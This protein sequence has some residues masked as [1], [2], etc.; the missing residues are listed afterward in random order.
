[1]HARK[2][3]VSKKQVGPRR[4][5]RRRLQQVVHHLQHSM[6]VMLR[7]PQGPSARRPVSRQQPN[8]YREGVETEGLKRFLLTNQI[9]SEGFK[10]EL[11]L[12]E[13]K[14]AK[15]KTKCSA[16]MLEMKVIIRL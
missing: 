14:Q 15:H 9:E 2:A 7:L 13:V 6:P 10:Q 3:S 5:T 12:E 4:V 16:Y 11:L 8:L 1:M